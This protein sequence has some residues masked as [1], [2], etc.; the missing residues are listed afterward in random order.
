MKLIHVRLIVTCLAA[1]LLLCAVPAGSEPV[2]V[3]FN[4]GLVH[5]FLKLS[6]MDGVALADGDLM[7]TARGNRV[8][9]RLVFR[10]IDGSL[11]DETSVYSQRGQFH[12]VSYR[13]V[14][15]GPSFP[16]PLEIS[17]D[18]TG[19]ATVRYTDDHG[20]Q[21]T[22]NEHIDVPADLSNGVMLTVLKNIRGDAMPS[23]QSMIVA[24]PKPRLVKL[25]LSTAGEETFSTGHMQ[26]KA[27][28]YVLKV[29]I[30]GL[31]G[32]LA[33]LV[34]KQPPDSHVWILSGAVPAFVKSE[35]PFY[36]GGPLWRI[37]LVSPVWPHA[38]AAR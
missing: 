5:G 8:T 24:T 4:E 19:Q 16:R 26:R 27:N 14:Q 30:G 7:Q 13:L 6:A 20:Q 22:E 21:K 23:E 29:D 36:M 32:L 35:Q 11:H 17:I 37:E 3:R 1:G 25:K 2:A 15:K 34:G 28:H 33:P 12:V 38:Q 18:A 31:S 10:F 9:S